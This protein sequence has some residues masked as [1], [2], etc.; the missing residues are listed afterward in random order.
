MA[1]RYFRL[2]D[3]AWFQLATRKIKTSM[4]NPVSMKNFVKGS[5]KV[6][7]EGGTRLALEPWNGELIFRGWKKFPSGGRNIRW[8]IF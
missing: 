2:G 8:W 5:A 6:E 7:E 4:V 3:G 1:S